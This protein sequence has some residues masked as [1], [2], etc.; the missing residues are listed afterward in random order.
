VVWT[1]L[2]LLA[3]VLGLKY[4]PKGMA[5]GFS[6]MSILLALPV[7]LYAIHGTPVRLG[8]IARALKHPLLA[9]SIPTALGVFI[10]MNALNWAPL[11]LRAIAGPGLVLLCYA[12]ILLIALRQWSFYHELLS[13]LLPSRR[14]A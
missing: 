2:V 1:V 13:H 6:G 5:I 11:A 8:D 10:R 4:G 3:F 9:I 12:F 7:C 14:T